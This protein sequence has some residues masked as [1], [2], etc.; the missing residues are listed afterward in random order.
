ME[1]RGGLVIV[2][3]KP[4]LLFTTLLLTSYCGL[5]REL[6]MKFSF[7]FEELQNLHIEYINFLFKPYFFNLFIV[8]FNSINNNY[9]PIQSK[10]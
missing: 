10:T 3:R 8:Y 5:L 7:H 6:L 4:L 1:T 2:N 9:A